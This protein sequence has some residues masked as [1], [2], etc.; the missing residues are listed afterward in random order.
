MSDLTEKEL[1]LKDYLYY[2][3]KEFS[4]KG[5]IW[6]KYLQHWDEAYTQLVKIVEEYFSVI[7]TDMGKW[8]YRF[9]E[10]WKGCSLGISDKEAEEAY[11]E[12]CKRLEKSIADQEQGVD[13][14]KKIEEIRMM[15]QK[16]TSEYMPVYRRIYLNDAVEVEIRKLLTRQPV[17]V[18]EDIENLIEWLEKR[19]NARAMLQVS[20]PHLA[21]YPTDEDKENWQKVKQLLTQKRVVKG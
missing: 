8:L 3:F 21:W 10:S 19:V 4:P 7:E 1:D 6:M 15:I 20:H 9:Y 12:I 5:G 16:A 13:E 17:Q 14:E 11:A 2:A 18:D